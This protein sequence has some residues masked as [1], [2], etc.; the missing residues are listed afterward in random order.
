MSLKTTAAVSALLFSCSVYAGPYENDL[1]KCLVEST[2]K[3]DRASLVR[4]MFAM[5]AANPAVGSIANVSPETVDELNATTGALFMRLLTDSCK[6][7][8]K[9]ALEYEG[10][11]TL[12]IGFRVL[13]AVAGKELFSSPEVKQAMSGLARN[14]D[15]NRLEQLLKE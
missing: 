8:A 6:N 5:A 2:T 9:N 10:S 14:V 12:R 15:T 3:E 11:G 4:W 13:G 1:A 7:E